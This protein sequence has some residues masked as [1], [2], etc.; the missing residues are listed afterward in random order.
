MDGEKKIPTAILMMP[1]IP[2]SITGIMII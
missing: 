2:V 1:V